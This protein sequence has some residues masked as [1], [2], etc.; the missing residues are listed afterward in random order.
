MERLRVLHKLGYVHNDVK[1]EN[2]LVGNQDPQTLYLIDFG[3]ST[4]FLEQD[5]TH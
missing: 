2:M 3:L 1:L 5:G 4:T